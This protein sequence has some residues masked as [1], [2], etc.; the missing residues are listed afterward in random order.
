MEG[1]TTEVS[2]TMND[3]YNKLSERVSDYN[4]KLVLHSAAVST[5]IGR[6]QSRLNRE[7]ARAI[8]LELIKRGGPAFQ[9]GKAMYQSVQ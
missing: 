6:D 2:I 4:A 5:G 8:C 1:N 3:F 9:V 7:E